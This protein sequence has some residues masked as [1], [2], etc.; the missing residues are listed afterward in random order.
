MT[1][2]HVSR[3][4]RLFV[5]VLDAL[6]GAVREDQ[7]VAA[8]IA[9]FQEINRERRLAQPATQR[10]LGYLRKLGVEVPEGLTRAEA[11]ALIDR[12]LERKR[13]GEAK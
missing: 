10:Q 7:L 9:V 2:A 8:A 11:S 13:G 3:Q 12:A 6:R 4:V 1:D 5:E